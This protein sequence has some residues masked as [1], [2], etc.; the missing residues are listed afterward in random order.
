MRILHVTECYAGGVSRAI[1]TRVEAFPNAEHHL[2]WSGDERPTNNSIFETTTVLPSGLLQ[3]VIRTRSLVKQL[4]VDIVHAHSSWAG[5]YT[6]LFSSSR[7]L[8]YEPHC[9]K[10]DDPSL[11]SLKRFVFRTA[12]KILSR[13]TSVFGVLTE[14]EKEL[15]RGLASRIPTVVIP[16]VATITQDQFCDME[17]SSNRIRVVMIGRLAPQKD[18]RFFMRT[19]ASLRSI[20]ATPV[21]AVWIGDGDSVYKDELHE[22][23]IDV[24]GWLESDRVA[25]ELLRSTI[26]LHT[27][28]YEGFPLSVLDAA[29]AQT[30]IIARRIPAFEHTTLI[31]ADTEAELASLIVEITSEPTHLD[32]AKTRGDELLSTMNLSQL[33]NALSVLY[34]STDQQTYQIPPF[35]LDA[36]DNGQF[37]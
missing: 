35:D 22:A 21:E 13:N 37:R 9:F 36:P 31:Q 23:G 30:P 33:T 20:S 19:I 12:E 4:D 27:A 10:F 32:A 8:V 1:E 24:T 2:L 26:Y 29:T 17:L 25:D 3:R 7:P 11:S 28:S 6:R 14:H 18:P 5:V 16:N 34:K 15:V